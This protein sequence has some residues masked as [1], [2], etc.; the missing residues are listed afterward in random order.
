MGSA[1]GKWTSP[2]AGLSSETVQEPNIS[3]IGQSPDRFAP[4]SRFGPMKQAGGLQN[5]PLNFCLIDQEDNL[6]FGTLVDSWLEVDET[7]HRAAV[8]DGR[9]DV[10]PVFAARHDEEEEEEEDD[11]EDDDEEDD[12]EDDT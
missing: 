12:D 8:L 11:E 6:M 7:F 4:R 2:S 10:L 1:A 3:E 9:L 5:A